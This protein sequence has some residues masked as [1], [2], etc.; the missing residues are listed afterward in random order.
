MGGPRLV[1]FTDQTD[2][3]PQPAREML[4]RHSIGSILAGP[5]G[6]LAAAQA[7]TGPVEGLVVGYADVDAG[8]LD[9]LPALRVIATSST[10]LDMIDLEATRARGVPVVPLT[11]AST[12]EVATHAV[13]LMLAVERQLLAGARTVAAGG[14]T[15]EA[16][17]L[18]PAP[19][20]LSDLTVGLLGCGR[21][22]RRV[23]ALLRPLVG[24]IIGHDPHQDCPEIHQVGVEE[25]LRRSDVLSLHAPLTRETR[26]LLDEERLALL[27]HGAT[28]INCARGELVDPD[29]LL[30][31]L[32][33]GRLRGVGLDVLPGEPP[34]PSSPLRQHPQVVCTP[35]TAFWSAPA[36][37]TY[38]LQPA[39]TVLEHLTSGSLPAHAV[40]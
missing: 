28:L 38:S 16:T 36:L 23:A 31:A 22:A 19:R 14:W 39:R 34:S 37:E 9:A 18:T 6:P 29:A 5:E 10:G 12:E 7:A 26:G 25:L 2:L 3:D 40:L 8:L 35:H 27:P 21:I 33:S 17:G 32:D 20:R 13:A 11:D 4:A 1:L 15:Q 24:E 30:S